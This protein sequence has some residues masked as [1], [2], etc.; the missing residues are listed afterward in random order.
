MLWWIH[1]VEGSRPSRFRLREHGSLRLH[2]WHFLISRKTRLWFILETDLATQSRS[3][4]HIVG[5]ATLYGEGGTE[6]YP[7]SKLLSGIR[8]QP[9]CMGAEELVKKVSF[10]CFVDQRF[11]KIVHNLVIFE[12]MLLQNARKRIFH[13]LSS[14]PPHNYQMAAP[15]KSKKLFF[16]IYTYQTSS[17][18]S[19]GRKKTHV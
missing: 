6:E 5:E 4:V 18:A 8:E 15:L 3:S 14:G 11:I 17:Y 9:F 2:H 13:R 10:R 12:K 16:Q 7:W 1:G 19:S